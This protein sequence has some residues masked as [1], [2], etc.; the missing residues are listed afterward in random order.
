MHRKSDRV[1]ESFGG[2]HEWQRY[3]PARGW[4]V[5][6]LFAQEKTILSI[7]T[8]PGPEI[9]RWTRVCARSKFSFKFKV[10]ESGSLLGHFSELW[11]ELIVVP[12]S[13]IPSLGMVLILVKVFAVCLG[14]CDGD[15][16]THM[17][18]HTQ[19][20]THTHKQLKV[21]AAVLFCWND[22]VKSVF[23]K[24]WFMTVHYYY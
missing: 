13:L 12:F 1:P 6:F 22:C 24:I 19:K 9:L 11:D 15:T 21:I 7:Q 10:A 20:N 17:D 23:K 3:S 2:Q 8:K 16:D 5:R 4:P 18:T 14:N